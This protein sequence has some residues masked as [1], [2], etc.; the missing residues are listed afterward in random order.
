MIDC[1]N[2]DWC[3]VEGAMGADAVNA[4]NAWKSAACMSFLSPTESVLTYKRLLDEVQDS[5][6]FA[7]LVER[8]PSQSSSSNSAPT[9]HAHIVSICDGSI[10]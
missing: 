9:Y 3:A 5:S 1:I 10:M 2:S 8:R 7:P 6:Y 4:Y